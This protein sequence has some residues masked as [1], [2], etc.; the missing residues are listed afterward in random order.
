[1]RG[2]EARWLTNIWMQDDAW[3]A[4]AGAAAVA[5]AVGVAREA[6]VTVAEGVAVVVVASRR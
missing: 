1:M 3:V 5:I 4:V 6:G 2:V